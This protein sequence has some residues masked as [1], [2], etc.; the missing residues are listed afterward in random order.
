MANAKTKVVEVGVIGQTYEDRKSGR[1]GVLESREEKFKTLMMKDDEGK[2]FNITFS[3]FRS[4]WRKYQGEDVV[5]TSEQKEEK[6]ETEKAE[7]QKKV[8]KA[9]RVLKEV[10]EAVSVPKVDKT[11]AESALKDIIE[12][13]VRESTFPELKVNKNSRGGVKVYYKNK[14]LMGAYVRPIESKYT[15]DTSTDIANMIDVGDIE[16]EKIVHEEWRI[17]TKFRFNEAHLDDML[18]IFLEAII[19]YTNENYVKN[20]KN[21]KTEEE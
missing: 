15:F 12:T 13:A 5:L 10:N 8:D 14:L 6:Q 11:K 1:K 9:K 7:K 21:E 2:T 19:K 17:S 16:V 18:K 20:E 4:N 3:T